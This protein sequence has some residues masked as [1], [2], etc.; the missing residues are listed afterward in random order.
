MCVGFGITCGERSS[1]PLCCSHW[2]CAFL[3]H[4]WLPPDVKIDLAASIGERSVVLKSE[5]RLVRGGDA[6]R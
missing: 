1:G 6:K 4:R 2:R 5:T 3:R